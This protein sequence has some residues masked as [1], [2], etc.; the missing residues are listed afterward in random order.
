[1]TLRAW[2]SFQFDNHGWTLGGQNRVAGTGQSGLASLRSTSGAAQGAAYGFAA[3]S[4]LIVGFCHRFTNHSSETPIF[5]LGTS[6]TIQFQLRVAADGAIIAS[7]GSGAGTELGRTVPGIINN[8]V[9]CYIEI[10]VKASTTVGEVEVHVN[11]NP[12]PILN[13]AGVNTGAASYNEQTFLGDGADGTRDYSAW[14]L[15]E[16]D[17]T[18][19][20]DF[21]GH[22]RF[23][24]PQPTGNGNSSQLVGSDG[25]GVDNYLLVDDPPLTHD[26]DAT[27]VQSGTVGEK[28]TYAMDNLPTTPLSIIAVCPLIIATK[29][30]AG[31]RSIKQVVRSGGADYDGDPAFL[32]TS[33]NTFKQAF[34]V[35]PSTG[36]AW[37]ESAVNA[38][39]TGVKVAS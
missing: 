14:Y 20:N 23:A 30:D 17:A 21:L 6:G 31:T 24:A 35:D 1:M 25:N 38:I 34:I 18:A 13:L 10:R 27:Y 33:Y 11:G 2:S 16:V 5:R 32:G 37:T 4:E 26:S 28:D 36:V 29:T 9:E 15:I 39:E 12:T 8:N 22:I 7:R 19:P 3:L